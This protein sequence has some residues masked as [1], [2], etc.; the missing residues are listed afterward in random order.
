M[1]K[2]EQNVEGMCWRS[3]T[4]HMVP[5]YKEFIF[6]CF[7]RSGYPRFIRYIFILLKQR[8]LLRFMSNLKLV[9]YEFIYFYFFM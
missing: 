1:P 2:I 9:S 8:I 5:L 3:N 6:I 7:R 4:F